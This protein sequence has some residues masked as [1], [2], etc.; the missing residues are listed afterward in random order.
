MSRRS[1]VDDITGRATSGVKISAHFLMLHSELVKPQCELFRPFWLS[2]MWGSNKMLNILST[3][4]GIRSERQIGRFS[5]WTR[6]F[7]GDRRKIRSRPG[8]LTATSCSQVLVRMDNSSRTNGPQVCS[9][10]VGEN[11][12]DYKQRC[13]YLENQLEKFREQATKVREVIGQKV[14]CSFLF[15]DYSI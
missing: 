7:S 1:R 3:E 2:V 5:H 9:T 12:I 4:I 14:N 13:K 6:D 15:C 10:E 11:E 8:N